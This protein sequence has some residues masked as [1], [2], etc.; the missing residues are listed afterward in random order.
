MGTIKDLPET[1]TAILDCPKPP[2]KPESPVYPTC[3]LCRERE[4]KT[5]RP[6]VVQLNYFPWLL[7][8]S[9][10]RTVREENAEEVERER[11]KQNPQCDAVSSVNRNQFGQDNSL[12]T[13]PCQLYKA[14]ASF[15]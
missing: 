10:T 5:Y 14:A 3:G 12:F 13:T 2:L 6:I 4:R 1:L 9:L 11:D 7:G 15:L 8:H